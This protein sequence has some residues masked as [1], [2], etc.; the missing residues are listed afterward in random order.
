MALEGL[1][2]FCVF[3]HTFFHCSWKWGTYLRKKKS[4]GG[5]YSGFIW[6]PRDL[7]LDVLQMCNQYEDN[8]ISCEC[9][10][11]FSIMIYDLH[12]P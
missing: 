2:F 4:F 8:T 1:S 5:V 7:G 9:T 10:I 12:A 11:W 3:K 6:I